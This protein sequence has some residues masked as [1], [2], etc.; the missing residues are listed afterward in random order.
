MMTKK[1]V[2]AC[3]P[4]QPVPLGLLVELV[5]SVARFLLDGAA[6]SRLFP[7]SIFMILLGVLETSRLSDE[8]DPVMSASSARAD[9][10]ADSDINQKISDEVPIEHPLHKRCNISVCRQ[11]T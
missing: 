8:I 2:I 7:L 6:F 4:T 3:N 10:S 9:N 11:Q 5:L 1:A